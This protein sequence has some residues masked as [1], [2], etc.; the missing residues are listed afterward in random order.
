MLPA[1][2]AAHPAHARQASAVFD[3]MERLPGDIQAVVVLNDAA[4]QRRSPAADALRSLLT[5]SGRLADIVS[6]WPTFSQALGWDPEACFDELLGR[7]VML[8]MRG[9]SRDD[10]R[11]WALLSDVTPEAEKRL[12][13]SLKPAPR[14]IVRGYT[15]L[16][17]ERGRYQLAVA[18]GGWRP[19]SGAQSTT[20]LLAPS[21]ADALFDEMLSLLAQP[22][23]RPT[24]PGRPDVADVL[25]ILRRN[26]E[27][28]LSGAMPTTIDF[29]L[30]ASLDK[31]GGGWTAR[32]AGISATGTVQVTPWS[33]TAFEG[34][35]R[36]SLIA[37]MG[38]IGATPLRDLAEWFEI[39][40][41][42][43]P[44]R[45]LLGQRV[46]LVVRGVEWGSTGAPSPGQPRIRQAAIVTLALETR[47]LSRIVSGGDTATASLVP[48]LNRGSV[49]DAAVTPVIELDPALEESTPRAVQLSPEP[50]A[51]AAAFG[52][53][54]VLT[55]AYGRSRRA[56]AQVVGT[57]PPETTPGWWVM[58]LAPR[59]AVTAR[60][61]TE[62]VRDL[63]GRES[64]DPLQLQRLSV[65]VVRPAALE[66]YMTGLDPGTA[67]AVRGSRWIES[68]RWDSWLRPDGSGAFEGELSVRMRSSAVVS[69]P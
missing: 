18:R 35:Q 45:T 42:A 31:D 26:V 20:I 49:M 59:V 46:A 39:P 16:A 14:G 33:M 30:R 58:S 69:R 37:I 67:A 12:L 66:R 34:L 51:P 53:D 5:E 36:G 62:D 63:L 40:R 38:V 64:P 11:E 25:L 60:S 28:A 10:V 65:G 21:R 32:L 1:L 47:D 56:L 8:V 19:E 50:G 24:Q 27:H 44:P 29:T 7:R 61:A 41:L 6:C 48:F 4:R 68:V 15:V 13:R 9:V 55:W 23:P 57:A 54:P 52:P 43:V 2:C 22:G 17:V 3:G